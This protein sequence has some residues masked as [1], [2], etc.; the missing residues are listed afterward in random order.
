MPC[1]MASLCGFDPGL[2][3]S[4]NLLLPPLHFHF[5]PPPPTTSPTL[6]H[7]LLSHILLLLLFTF[8]QEH[9]PPS[10]D[11]WSENVLDRKTSPTAITIILPKDRTNRTFN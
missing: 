4:G 11:C 1:D 2:G 5:L 10:H 7:I 3:F 8:L 9:F 6:L